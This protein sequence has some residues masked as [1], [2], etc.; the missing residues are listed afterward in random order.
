MELLPHLRDLER[1]LDRVH[2]LVIQ[3]LEFPRGDAA[4]VLVPVSA[5]RF[6]QHD[7]F[8][9]DIAPAARANLLGYLLGYLRP[10]RTITI[11]GGQW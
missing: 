10:S 2:E 3:P 8:C 11:L 6:S 4:S 1:F 9:R 7:T 5:V